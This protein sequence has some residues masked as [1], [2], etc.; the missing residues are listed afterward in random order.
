M[1]YT[2]LAKSIFINYILNQSGTANADEPTVIMLG[3]N[4]EYSMDATDQNIIGGGSSCTETQKVRISLCIYPK[5]W[6]RLKL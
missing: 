4:G 2:V 1:E 3:S 6:L 5:V